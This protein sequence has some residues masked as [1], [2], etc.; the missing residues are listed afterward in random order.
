MTAYADFDDYL[1]HVRSPGQRLVDQRDSFT[2]IAARAQ[3]SWL[4]TGSFLGPGSTPSTAV[5]PTRLT[6]GA[7]GQLNDVTEQRLARMDVTRN[8]PA[9]IVIADRL[10]HQGGLSGT[11]TGAQT[12]NLPTAALTRYTD[13]VG[14]MAAIEIYSAIGGTAR[15]FTVSYTN[16]AGTSGQ[17]SEA[18]NIG[19]ANYSTAGRMLF[20]PLQA[21]DSGIRAVASVTISAST[22]TAG[23]FGVTLFKPLLAFPFQ[24]AS[25]W[26]ITFDGLLNLGGQLPVVLDDACLFS[27]IT[28]QGTFGGR[29]LYN[30]SFTDDPE[31]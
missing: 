16:Q 2:G 28:P 11:T 27:V 6:A 12:T 13:G 29:S 10:S 5:V 14:V 24:F 7:M 17:T 21:G 26:A 18:S 8:G 20:V 25:N 3:S 22:G 1:A 4:T 15:T 23:N 31:A 30:M 19:G 9:Y